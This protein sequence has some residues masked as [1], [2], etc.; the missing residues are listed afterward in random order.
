MDSRVEGNAVLIYQSATT[1]VFRRAGTNRILK[2]P[3]GPDA[4]QRVRE[5]G[6]IQERNHG[7]RARERQGTQTRSLAAGQN[8]RLQGMGSG[9]YLPGDQA[10][11]SLMS[12]TG[13]PSRIG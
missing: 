9:H 10:S 3:L 12:I 11:A 2:E 6:A 13:I 8:D 4:A 7:L 5:E 1:R